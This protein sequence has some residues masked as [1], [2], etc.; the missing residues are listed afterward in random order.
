MLRPHG[1]IPITHKCKLNTS[2]PAGRAGPHSHARRLFLVFRLDGRSS[3]QITLQKACW[4]W[5]V[6]VYMGH[7]VE[8][9]GV[10]RT[11]FGTLWGGCR[12]S[13]DMMILLLRVVY[14]GQGTKPPGQADLCA[15]RH[16]KANTPSPS[17]PTKVSERGKPHEGAILSE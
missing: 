4:G 10:P 15:Q 14:E 6:E 9:P 16:A 7:R 13:R 2:H 8:S 12:L 11:G 1:S 5:N 17:Q 3:D